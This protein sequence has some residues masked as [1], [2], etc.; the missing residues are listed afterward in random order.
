M[1]RYRWVPVAR[2][3]RGFSALRVHGSD[4]AEQTT[5]PAICLGYPPRNAP[6]LEGAW[7]DYG[8]EESKPHPECNKQLQRGATLIGPAWG[9]SYTLRTCRCN[10]ANSLGRRHLAPAVNK[11]TRSVWFPARLVSAVRSF[12]YDRYSHAE[13][14]WY[15]K[16]PAAKQETIRASQFRDKFQR[17][18]V[19]LSVK[20]E[21]SHKLPTKA[22]GIQMYANQR[23]QAEAG[24]RH[25]IFQKALGDICKQHPSGF[26]LFAGIYINLTSGWSTAD[27]DQW[28][29]N[30]AGHEWFN[31]TDCSNFDATITPETTAARSRFASAVDARLGDDIRVGIRFRGI[32]RAPKFLRYGG[33]GTVK[34]GHSDTTW[35]NSIVTAVVAAI[36]MLEGGCT[37]SILAAG[38]DLL[39]AGSRGDPT[40]IAAAQTSFGLTP[41]VA[42]WH[43]L[44]DATFISS[45]FLHDGRGWRFTPMVGRLLKRMWWTTSPPTKRQTANRMS[46]DA[47]GVLTSHAGHPIFEA[48]LRKYVNATP[49]FTKEWQHKPSGPVRGQFDYL[50]ALCARYCLSEGE[51][52]SIARQVD[53][54]R[55]AVVY[56]ELEQFGVDLLDAPD[57]TSCAW[58][59]GVGQPRGGTMSHDMITSKVKALNL[60]PQGETWVTKALYPPSDLSRVQMP[61]KTHYPTL[62]IDFRPSTVISRP[63]GL[64]VGDTWDLL[65]YSPPSDATALV[66][67]SGPAGT[68]FEQPTVPVGGVSGLLPSVP[69]LSAPTVDID[70]VLRVAA[71]TATA[72]SVQNVL[73][74][75]RHQ[76][77]RIT[78]KSYTAHMTASDLYN[79]GTVT[80]AQYDTT[81]EPS[82]GWVR[83]GSRGAVPCLGS[84]PL[85]ETEITNSSPYAVVSEAKD[86]IFVPHRI[87]GPTFDFKKP[88]PCYNR[89]HQSGLITE[90]TYGTTGCALTLGT[91]P[92]FYTVDGT[93]DGYLPWWIA[94]QYAVTSRPDDANFDAVTSGVSIFRGLNYEATITLIS[95]VGLECVLQS[96]S[97][98]RTMASNP[99]E[100]DPRAL[101]AYYEI[102]ARMPHAYPASYNALGLVLPAI[103]AAVRAILPHLPKIASL[104]ASAVPLIKPIVQAVR[105]PDAPKKAVKR[106]LELVEAIRPPTQVVRVGSS[107]RKTA[108]ARTAQTARGPQR[109]RRR[110]KAPRGP[111]PDNNNFLK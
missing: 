55:G 4:P 96:E 89:T 74:P 90:T 68:N 51:L 6:L 61:T 100:P 10:A 103:G 110:A 59:S 94:T 111:R 56:A 46:G 87:M 7:I 104:V 83:V 85:N 75:L 91:V 63:A 44:A 64:T 95:H 33:L 109:S 2:G 20:R 97:A 47:L 108:S 24:W 38:D 26:E 42:M 105:A 11:A 15:D 41:K 92:A 5:E 39:I 58:G 57:R 16:W 25:R 86:G 34:S 62:A 14:E 31:E 3:V 23:T 18:K 45:C 32:H 36:G 21:S 40:R 54:A 101:L 37:G 35:G 12:Y 107:R 78:S 28:A 77:F 70:Y 99:P 98:F 22:R 76:G 9:N 88:L 69:N 73:N 81:Y 29:E 1:G 17:G 66:W 71:G 50:R 102:S 65:V 49:T 79:S 93:H 60:S 72:S 106:P 53:E 84:V 80:T 19:E 8:Y 13:Q 30:H 52:L 27:F 67:A 82:V 48:L 43:H